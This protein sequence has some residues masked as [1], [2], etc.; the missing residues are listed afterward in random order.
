MSHWSGQKFAKSHLS[1]LTPWILVV[2][3]TSQGIHIVIWQ[4]LSANPPPPLQKNDAWLADIAMLGFCRPK[5]PQ[6]TLRWLRVFVH[7]Y[8][9]GV[10]GGP[11]NSYFWGFRI[12]GVQDINSWLIVGLGPGGLESQGSPQKKGTEIFGGQP[13]IKSQKNPNQQ[14]QTNNEPWTKKHLHLKISEMPLLTAP[15]NDISW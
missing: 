11:Q 9:A 6:G 10:F 8:E 1:S 4:I 14:P 3:P 12:F 2:K 5:N 15:N 7:L 13:M